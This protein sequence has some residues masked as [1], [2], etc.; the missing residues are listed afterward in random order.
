MPQP[1]GPVTAANW[2]KEISQADIVESPDAILAFRIDSRDLVETNHDR[3]ETGGV[4]TENQAEF[5]ILDETEDFLAVHKPAG[6]LVHPTKPGGPR[7][8]WDGLCELLGYELAT[9]GRVSLV[10]RLDRETSGVLLVAKNARAAR[11][12]GMAMQQG[13]V[14]KEYVALVF[15]WPAWDEEIVDGPILR[16]GRVASSAVWLERTVHPLGA[17]AMTR[18]RVEKRL[19]LPQDRRF[20]VLRA[21]PE[22]GRTHQIRV[23]LASVGFP[24]LG[25]K[26][27][28]RGNHHYLDFIDRGWVEAMAAELWLPRHAL[29]SARLC[30]KLYG[31]EF[32]WSSPLPGD[33]AGLIESAEA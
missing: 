5:E 24:I 6:L 14:R 22:T 17:P 1:L 15:G 11:A 31:Q 18:F 20:S 4:N 23:H 32:D 28:A 26:I 2:P 8:L 12:A 16:L 9:G 21:R 19:S 27:Y 7:T 33:M 10:N 3:F 30:L 29:H 13:G 25:D